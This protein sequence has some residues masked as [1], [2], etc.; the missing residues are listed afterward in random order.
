MSNW[1]NSCYLAFMEHAQKHTS[2]T[3]ADSFFD[4]MGY[5]IFIDTE[6]NDGSYLISNQYGME[7]YQLTLDHVNETVKIVAVLHTT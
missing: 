5:R 4:H 6:M 2:N 1:S 7:D 3:L